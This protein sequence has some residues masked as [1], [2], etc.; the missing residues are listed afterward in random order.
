MN[1]RVI[2]INLN[3]IPNDKQ[4]LRFVIAAQRMGC[5]EIDT[6]SVQHCILQA[7]RLKNY[8]ICDLLGLG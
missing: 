5:R 8:Y 1:H 4:K 3:T 7:A 2:P 6:T